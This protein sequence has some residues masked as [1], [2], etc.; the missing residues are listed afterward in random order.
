MR[1]KILV[2]RAQN[3]AIDFA[4]I[5]EEKGFETILFPVIEFA[6]PRDKTSLQAVAQKLET[7]DWLILT[8]ANCVKYF[9][10]ALQSEGK[11]VSDLNDLKVCAIGPKTAD[12][13]RYVGLKTSLIPKSYQAEGIIETLKSLGMEGRNIL[14]PRAEEGRDILPDGLRIIGANVDLVP[15]YRAVRPEGLEGA[16]ESILK[17]GIDVITFTSASIVKNFMQILGEENKKLLKGA[18]I[19]CLS[20]ITAGAAEQCG[21]KTDIL[22]EENTTLSLAEAIRKNLS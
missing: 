8:S 1:K 3:Q 11:S 19:A 12:A 21:L 6:P 7:Y 13:A 10:Q 2:T 15:V 16:L 20:D 5:L 18:K 14:F 4:D 22:P 17:E 9:I